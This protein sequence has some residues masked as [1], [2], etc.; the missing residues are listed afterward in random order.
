MKTILAL[1]CVSFLAPAF[2]NNAQNSDPNLFYSE[3]LGFTFVKRAACR[4]Y[5]G[6]VRM[7]QFYMGKMSFGECKGGTYDGHAIADTF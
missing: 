1:V 4:Q 3:L 6:K 5:G 7:N 2:A